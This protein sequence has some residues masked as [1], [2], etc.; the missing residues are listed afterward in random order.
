[1]LFKNSNLNDNNYI[2]KMSQDELFMNALLDFSNLP[3]RRTSSFSSFK[4]KH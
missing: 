1:M 4:E 2:N 3:S